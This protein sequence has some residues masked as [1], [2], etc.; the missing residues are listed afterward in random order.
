VC[1]GV[2][3]AGELLRKV[4]M[5][6]SD[7]IRGTLHAPHY[8][9]VRDAGGHSDAHLLLLFGLTGYRATQ[10]P[11][12]PGRFA[13]LAGDGAWTMLADDW[14]YT[15]WS[16]PTTDQ[17]IHQLGQTHDVFACSVGDSDHSFDFVYYRGG[18][19]VRRY[20]VVDPDYRGGRVVVNTGEPIPGEAAAFRERDEWRIVIAIVAALGIRSNYT[21][22]EIRAYVPSE[23]SP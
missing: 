11:R 20:V 22:E 18:R 3:L 21:A 12:R 4:S 17:A 6:D 15:L 13:L 9:F 10:S 5:V 23:S 7:F 8:I 1:T 16:R 19:V 2:A 14:L